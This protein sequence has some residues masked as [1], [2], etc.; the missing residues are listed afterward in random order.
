MR[1]TT[2]PVAV[3]LMLA[4]V[5]PAHA[6][7]VEGTEVRYVGGSMPGLRAGQQ[8]LLNLTMPDQL[9]FEHAGGTF[10]I[11]YASMQRFV[12]TAP[13]ARR[14]G[15]IPTIAVVL[16]KHRQRRHL[17]E[18]HFRDQAGTNHSIVFEVSKQQAKPVVAVLSARVPRP[19]PQSS[20]QRGTGVR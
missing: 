5:A 15:V 3:L 7:G 11:P 18:L 2:S 14:M 19:A 16:V 20:G 1:L 10:A 8:G 6:K 17:V 9:L 13:L 4:I 12:Y